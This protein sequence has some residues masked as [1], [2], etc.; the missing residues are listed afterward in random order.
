MQLGCQNNWNDRGR[1]RHFVLLGPTP[2]PQVRLAARMQAEVRGGPS[3]FAAIGVPEGSEVRGGRA[4]VEVLA[5]V[6]KKPTQR[7][8]STLEDDGPHHFT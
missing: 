4:D 3:H 8:G 7:R 1:D 6:H 2:V 5:D